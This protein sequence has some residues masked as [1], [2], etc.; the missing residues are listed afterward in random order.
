MYIVSEATLFIVGI[1]LVYKYATTIRLLKPF[2]DMYYVVAIPLILATGLSNVFGIMSICCYLFVCV[3]VANKHIVTRI[4][5]A[6][7]FAAILGV[8]HSIEKQ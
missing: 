7:V 5:V 1:I 6:V 8:F 3:L 4:G 2:A